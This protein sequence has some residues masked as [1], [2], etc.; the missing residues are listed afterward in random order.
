MHANS[1]VVSDALQRYRMLVQQRNGLQERKANLELDLRQF[2]LDPAVYRDGQIEQIRAEYRAAKTQLDDLV[3]EIDLLLFRSPELRDALARE[4]QQ[5]QT[6]PKPRPE[7]H[8]SSESIQEQKAVLLRL[9]EVSPQPVR[10]LWRSRIPLGKVTVVD[11]DPGLGKS[12]LSTDIAARV[13]TIETMPDGTESDLHE[14]VGVVILSAEDELA[15]TIRPR[16][17]VAGADLSRVVALAAINTGDDTRLPVLSDLEEIREAIR[18]VDARLVII[19]PLMAYLPGKIDS[20]RDQDIRR[21]LAPLAALA[22]ETGVAVLVIRHLNK[23]E[24]RNALY[25]GG[26]SIGIIGAARSGLLVAKDPEDEDRRILVVTKSN[27][28]KLPP[29]LAYR[30]TAN[31]NEIPSLSWEGTTDHTAASLLAQPVNGEDRST[32]EEA[33]DFLRDVLASGAVPARDIQKQADQAGISYATLRRA[34]TA[35]TL[36]VRKQGGFFSK[37]RESQQWCWMLP[38]GES[39]PAA[40]DAQNPSEDAQT[41]EHE[42]LQQSSEKNTRKSNG[43]AEDAQDSENGHLQGGNEHLQEPQDAEVL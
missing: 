29:A 14:P 2:G 35:L 22:A 41:R 38:S 39:Y 43:F 19:D 26:G 3:R 28:A 13:T 12:L 17:E 16:L 37:D 18:Q 5:S 32:L 24:G 11:G 31:A 15:D 27:L 40:E 23:A 1:A 9:S 25:R 20:H 30:I 42:H 4:A 6:L 8:A 34:K 36:I 21:S 7:D 33:K 10:W